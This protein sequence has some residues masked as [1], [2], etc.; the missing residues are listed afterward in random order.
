MDTVSYIIRVG[1]GDQF[2]AI[3]ISEKARLKELYEAIARGLHIHDDRPYCFVIHASKGPEAGELQ[4]YWSSAPKGRKTVRTMLKS[5]G[6]IEDGFRLY[7]FD[8]EKG[9]EARDEKNDIQGIV[10]GSVA[11][12]TKEA[13]VLPE[14][15][16]K[17]GLLK[18]DNC[19]ELTIW[20]Q[21]QLQEAYEKTGLTP[22]KVE[23][24]KAYLTAMA[25]L[26][27]IIPVG[28]AADI[29]EALEPGLAERE[30]FVAVTEAARHE[31]LPWEVLGEEEIY[32]HTNRK[33]SP[34][35]REIVADD[36]CENAF[37]EYEKLK[38]GQGG[39]PYYIPPAEELLR[40]ADENY[41]VMTPQVE[42]LKKWLRRAMRR[43]APAERKRVLYSICTDAEQNK[44]FVDI[45]HHLDDEVGRFKSEKDLRQAARIMI[46]MVNTTRCRWNRGYTAKE[47]GLMRD[48]P[49]MKV[50][51]RNRQGTLPETS[52]FDIWKR[53]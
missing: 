13:A 24:I 38:E 37:E 26:Y 51:N 20:S 33:S 21:Q 41:H 16:W 40:Y 36:L 31:M 42:A 29:V 8:L 48:D 15:D 19:R 53:H 45:L 10:M 4:F 34:E 18:I 2:C 7:Q 5:T 6:I 43:A 28:K 35:E 17:T 32:A 11:E 49:A 27:G 23:R 3:R 44:P 12:E 22:E 52:P 47:T 14:K 25:R 39:K 30:A 1:R 9:W 46:D 50:L